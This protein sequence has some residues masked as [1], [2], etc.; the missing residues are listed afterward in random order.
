MARIIQLEFR[1]GVTFE[2]E[3]F[4]DATPVT[5]QI[6]WESLPFTQELKHASYSGAAL[7]ADLPRNVRKVE[8]PYV[9]GCETGDLV[10][11][12]Q[13]TGIRVEGK[14]ILDELM[15][16]YGPVTF[17]NW[18]GWFPV[19]RFGRIIRGDLA[20][21]KKTGERVREFGKEKITVRRWE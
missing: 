19:N 8:N 7:Y 16:V 5:V 14:E 6:F 21:L 10:I 15:I 1:D 4:E 18:T 20:V 2:A 17:F 12:T 11:N 9:L 13:A 3:L